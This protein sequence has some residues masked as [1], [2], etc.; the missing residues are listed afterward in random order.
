MRPD[1]PNLD[2]FSNG[3]CLQILKCSKKLFLTAGNPNLVS[4]LKTTTRVHI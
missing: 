4:R 3:F 2:L 1:N